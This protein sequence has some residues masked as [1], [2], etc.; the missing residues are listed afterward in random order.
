MDYECCTGVT[1]GFAWTR[2]RRAG[3]LPARLPVLAHRAWFILLTGC[4]GTAGHPACGSSVPRPREAG[5]DDPGLLTGGRG[6][7]IVD[8]LADRWGHDGNEQGRVVWFEVTA[9]HETAAAE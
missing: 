4:G 6:L 7:R 8:V 2:S 1:S 5:D 3:R 9:K